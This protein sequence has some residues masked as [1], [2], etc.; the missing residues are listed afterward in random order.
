MRKNFILDTN[1]LLYDPNA[2]NLFADNNVL[3][4]LDVIEQLDTFKRDITE[5]GNNARSVIQQLDLLRQGAKLGEGVA[6]SSGGMLRVCAGDFQNMLANTGLVLNSSVDNRILNLAV[7]LHEHDSE[8]PTIIVTKSINLRIKADALGIY[9]E[10]FAEPN[11]TVADAGIGYH[12][13]ER[14]SEDIDEFVKVGKCTLENGE[15][16]PNAYVLFK[17]NDGSKKQALGRV[18][19]LDPVKVVRLFSV[20]EGVL[21]IKPLNLGQCFAMDALLDDNIKLVTLLGKAGTGKTLIAVAAGLYKVVQEDIYNRVIV[22][23][24][25][26][27]MGRDIGYIPGDIEEKMRPWMQPIFDAV[28]LIREIDRRS[29]RRSLPP[30]ILES[31]ELGIEPLTYIRGRSIPHQFMIVDEAQNLTP[32][33]VKTIVTRVGR[34]TKVVL[35]GDLHQIDNP[36]VDAYS[37][38]FSYVIDR[39]R[40]EKIAAHIALTKGERSEL[41]EVASN[42]L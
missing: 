8:H 7:Y 29:R 40:N 25:T 28:E 33:E 31:D 20:Q 26:M 1:V 16:T 6:L 37:N 36:Y 22:S 11:K 5:L 32:H 14:S 42:L 30:D 38:G 24:P 21:G 27:P 34:G 15:F 39:F 2:I 35:T 13:L 41:A 23:R 3:I 18:V 19:N 9:A 17:S 10:D 12:E 4:P